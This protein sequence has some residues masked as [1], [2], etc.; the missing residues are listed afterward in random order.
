MPYSEGHPQASTPAGS[1]KKSDCHL[2]KSEIFPW[3]LVC[4]FVCFLRELLGCL[5]S[6]GCFFQSV[7]CVPFLLITGTVVMPSVRESR[8]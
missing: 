7:F 1:T 3:L 4:L 8:F 2:P 5:V 6:V